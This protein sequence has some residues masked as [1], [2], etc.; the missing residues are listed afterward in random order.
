MGKRPLLACL[1]GLI[2]TICVVLFVAAVG[3]FTGFNLF[4]FSL[5]LVVPVGALLCGALALS[6]FYIVSHRVHL[7]ARLWMFVPLISLAAFAY[8]SIYYIEYIWMETTDGI[9]VSSFISFREYLDIAITSQTIYAGRG[10]RAQADLGDAGYWFAA[11]D[12]VG[13]VVGGAWIYIALQVSRACHTCGQY[14]RKR[15]DRVRYFHSTED[16]DDYYSGLFNHP[17]DSHEFTRRASLGDDKLDEKKP[18]MRIITQLHDCEGCH[19]QLW[20]DSPSAWNGKEWS[21][22]PSLDRAVVIPPEAHLARFVRGGI[23]PSW[24][25]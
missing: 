14:L 24:L 9:S 13:F 19:R 2:T 6:G 7:K 1:G 12:F 3:H 18:T 25:H 22:M 5:W 15:G 17:F 4:S 23:F 11:L 20:T 16:A 10:A 21:Q 8:L